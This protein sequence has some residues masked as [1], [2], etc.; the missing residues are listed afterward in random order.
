MIIENYL[1]SKANRI[2]NWFFDFCDLSVSIC[3]NEDVQLCN[4]YILCECMVLCSNESTNYELL[5]IMCAFSCH[6]LG[7]FKIIWKLVINCRRKNL[8]FLSRKSACGLLR[9]LTPSEVMWFQCWLM[10]SLLHVGLPRS[11]REASQF[12]SFFGSIKLQK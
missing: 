10:A 12:S 3:L 2:V 1:I 4:I 11:G 9:L 5:L 8:G 7:N 6:F